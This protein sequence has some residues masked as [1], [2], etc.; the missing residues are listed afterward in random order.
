MGMYKENSG[1]Q[2]YKKS[3]KMTINHSQLNQY[4]T[5]KSDQK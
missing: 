2:T 1:V 3:N 4:A 5:D